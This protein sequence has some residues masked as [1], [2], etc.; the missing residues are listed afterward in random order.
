MTPAPRRLGIVVLALLVA[1]FGIGLV[2]HA[3]G[4]GATRRSPSTSV[5]PSITPSNGDIYYVRGGGL[6]APEFRAIHPDGTGLRTAL[7]ST[8]DVHYHRIAFSPDGGMI[9]F[10]TSE[11]DR[12]GIAIAMADGSNVRRLTDGTNDTSP[13]W[14]PDGTRIAFAGTAFDPGIHR[15]S[16]G[17]DHDCPTDIYVMNA[18]GSD[19][20]RLTTDPAPDYHPIWSPDGTQIAFVTYQ[21]STDGVVS[22]MLADGSQVRPISSG[23]PGWASS[24]SWSPDGSLIVFAAAREHQQAIYGVA[25]DGSDEH[26]ILSGDGVGTPVWSPDGSRIAY[27]AIDPVSDV[28]SLYTMRPDGSDARLVGTDSPGGIASYITWRPVLESSPSP[29]A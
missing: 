10:A 6:Y 28:F 3:F 22:V 23:V 9:A 19:L 16:L 24:P 2:V 1:S 17:V 5:V 20:V 27:T 8:D 29:S 18:D 15:C 4:T 13:V 26:L 25:P 11:Y 14:S 7:A 21:P 12:S